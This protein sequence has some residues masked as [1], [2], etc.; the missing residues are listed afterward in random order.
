MHNQPG[1]RVVTVTQTPPSTVPPVSPTARRWGFADV[2]GWYLAAFLGQFVV[3]GLLRSAEGD[4]LPST[5][6]VYMLFLLQV[7]QWFAYGLGPLLTTTRRGD[8]PRSDLGLRIEAGDLLVGLPTGLVSQLLIIPLL[9]FPINKMVD[10]DPGDAARDLID[11]IDGPLDIILMGILVVVMAPLVEEIFY[12]GLLMG[13][14]RDRLPDTASIVLSGVIFAAVHF[15]PLQFPGLLVFGLILGYL[16]VRYDRLGPAWAAHL[17]F[18]A[19]TFVVL[20]AG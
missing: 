13:A 11:R 9:Y 12:R 17:A 1:A 16:R 6:P 2:G 20:V 19:V 5:L 15:Q 8:G 14:L 10:G 18:N 7:P 3:L 4:D